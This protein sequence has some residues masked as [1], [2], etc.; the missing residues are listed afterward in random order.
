MDY[1]SSSDGTSQSSDDFDIATTNNIDYSSENEESVENI[2]VRMSWK[3]YIT[4]L[5][6]SAYQALYSLQIK[7]RQTWHPTKYLINKGLSQLSID[8]LLMLHPTNKR[9]LCRIVDEYQHILTMKYM[10][11]TVTIDDT[12]IENENDTDLY[13]NESETASMTMDLEQMMTCKYLRYNPFRKRIRML[14][15]QDLKKTTDLTFFDF[16]QCLSVFFDGIPNVNKIRFSYRIYDM[17]DD[18][19]ISRQNLFDVI[20]SV[21]C[22]SND[23]DVDDEYDN[24][25]KIRTIVDQTFNECQLTQNGSN[26]DFTEFTSIVGVTDIAKNFTILF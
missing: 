14:F 20:Q 13:F 22:F 6:V 3:E 4:H 19:F 9:Q 24:E 17:E 12:G 2:K 5:K 21:I 1:F 16:M 7:W 26:I 18:G 15:E 10:S 25:R 23:F 11:N 8:E